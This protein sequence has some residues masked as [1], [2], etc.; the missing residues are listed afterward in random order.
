MNFRLHFFVFF[1]VLLPA[2]SSGHATAAF[3]TTYPE[4]D[5]LRR[6]RPRL[7][8]LLTDTSESARQERTQ[9]FYED[10]K[11]RFARNSFTRRLFNLIF[12]PQAG[13]SPPVRTN[14]EALEYF[15]QYQ[16]R[17]IRSVNIRKLDLFGPTVNDTTQQRSTNWLRRAGNALHFQTRDWVIEKNLLFEEGNPV[18]PELLYDNERLLRNLSYIRDARIRLK[19]VAGN[20]EAVDLVVITQDVLPLSVDAERGRFSSYSVEVQNSNIFG[21]GHR[22]RTG[23]VYRSDGTPAVGYSG[24]YT[25]ENVGGSFIDASIRAAY[26]DIEQGVGISLQRPFFTPETRWAGG[27]DLQRT[28]QLM[29]LPHRNPLQ[30]TLLHW[31]FNRIDAWAA[32]AIPIKS[33]RPHPHGRE[34]VVLAGRISRLYPHQAPGLELEGRN[35]F[36]DRRMFLGSVGWVQRQ[37][38]RDAYIYGFGRTEDVPLGATINVTMGLE[39]QHRASPYVQMST[40]YGTYF[41]RFGYFDVRLGAGQ[42]FGGDPAASRRLRWGSLG[43]I[44]SLLPLKRF[45]LRQLIHIDYLYGDSRYSYEFLSVGSDEIRGIRSVDLR[46]TQRI[47]ASAETILFSP[48]QLVGFRFAGFAFADVGY[49]NERDYFSLKGSSLQ[50]YGLG[51]RVRNENLAFKTFQIRF[52]YYPG[53]ESSFAISLRGSPNSVFRDF[54]IDRPEVH[55]YR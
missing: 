54:R 38:R 12:D 34:A 30:D 10:L 5:T 31:G 26:T 43:W 20:P 49:L 22:L 3:K 51:L 4:E 33:S 15:Q 25:V 24:A 21:I 37:Y 6:F 52:A 46:G 18:D 19:P 27:L 42:Y 55:P 50:G 48:W 35:F 7:V 11:A 16:G 1:C 32:H 41:E 9:L 2:A 29:V 45:T 44:S 47:V 8:L 23:I 13:P 39:S 17:I 28:E 40:G 36:L 53:Q 14:Q